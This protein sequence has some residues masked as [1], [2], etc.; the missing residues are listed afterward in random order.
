VLDELIPKVSSLTLISGVNNK[1]Q[2]QQARVNLIPPRG[3]YHWLEYQIHANI[4]DKLIARCTKIDRQ[5][6]AK[7]HAPRGPENA[8]LDH[9]VIDIRLDD[10]SYQFPENTSHA[11]LERGA[12]V[13]ELEGHCLVV[14]RAKKSN[15]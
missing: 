9:D 11:S 1:L 10:V 12:R 7:E 13:L 6:K 8:F 14:V 2:N 4:D 15:E 5:H 3:Q